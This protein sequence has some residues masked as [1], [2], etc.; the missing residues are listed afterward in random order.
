MN[1]QCQQN[2]TYVMQKHIT[3][4]QRKDINNANWASISAMDRG[5]VGGGTISY[6]RPGNGHVATYGRGLVR[7][8]HL[9]G[10]N[11][12]LGARLKVQTRTNGEKQSLREWGREKT[13][14]RKGRHWFW[15]RAENG[16]VTLWILAMAS[17]SSCW[18]SLSLNY[19]GLWITHGKLSGP[20]P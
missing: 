9:R 8:A 16:S 4:I 7:W 6:S 14:S 15:A 13:C 3:G 5:S 11:T 18:F 12:V 20:V 1:S 17:W 19:K 10:E 2:F